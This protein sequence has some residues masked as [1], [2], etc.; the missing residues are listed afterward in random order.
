MKKTMTIEGMRCEHCAAF[1]TKALKAVDGVSDAS[2]DLK[3]KTA[4]VETDADVADADLVAAVADAGFKA[5][6]VK[7]A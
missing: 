3:T 4:V 2:V 5:V 1:A 6:G 7:N